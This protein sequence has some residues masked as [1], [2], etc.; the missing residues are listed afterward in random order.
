MKARLFDADNHAVFWFVVA[1]IALV[2]AL[3]L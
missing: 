1:G 3:T 2:A